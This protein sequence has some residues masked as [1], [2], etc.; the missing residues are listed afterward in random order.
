MSLSGT[1]VWSFELRYGDPAEVAEAVAEL[2]ALGYSAAWIPDIGGDDLFEAVEHLLDSTSTMTVATGIL[3]IWM[4]T[5][6]QTAAW[7]AELLADRQDRLLLGLGIST[8]P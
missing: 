6:A 5:A 3:N 7:R 1:G 4:H 8:R 2:E